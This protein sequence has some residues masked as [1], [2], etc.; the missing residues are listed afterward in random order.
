MGAD[1][2]ISFYGTRYEVGDADDADSLNEQ[3]DSR[4]ALAKSGR[5]DT[6]IGRLT[7]GEPY[8][9][10]IGRRLGVFGVEGQSSTSFTADEISLIASQTDEKLDSL[11]IPGERRIWFQLEAQY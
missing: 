8:F 10:F 2:F 1:A 6:Y 7:D 9:L 5:L 4:L 11:G 3:N